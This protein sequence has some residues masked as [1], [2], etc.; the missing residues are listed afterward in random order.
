ME[1]RIE[2]MPLSHLKVAEKNPKEH[3]LNYLIESFSQFG[4]V[5]PFLLNEKTGSLVAGHGRLAALK[6]MKKKKLDPPARIEV[7][8]NEWLAPVIRGISFENKEEAEAFLIADNRLTEL[9]GW[10]P[11]MLVA[12]LE[13]LA[14]DGKLSGT[15]YD[16]TDLDRIRMKLAPPGE[17][18]VINGMGI[19][20][21][22]MNFNNAAYEKIMQQFEE[23]MN[24][25]NFEDHTAVFLYLLTKY[26]HSN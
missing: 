15:G 13:D 14:P 12:V 24:R 7:K 3:N 19:K 20:S 23:I 22:V 9:G 6:K 21:L 25:E 11:S 16:E 26:E 18:T 8:E 1:M 5:A 17:V 10:N 4:F 2:Y